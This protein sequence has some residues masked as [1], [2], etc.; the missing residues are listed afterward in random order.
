MTEFL[1][2]EIYSSWAEI[3]RVCEITCDFVLINPVLAM[4][5]SILERAKK[6]R[7]QLNGEIIKMWVMH[8]CVFLPFTGEMMQVSR[9]D[10][11]K[12]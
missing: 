10:R 12:L 4:P 5:Q 6:A 8:Q 3:R 1:F 9:K 11:L 2:L 7:D